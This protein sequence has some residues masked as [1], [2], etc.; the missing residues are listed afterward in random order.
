MQ[1]ADIGWNDKATAGLVPT[2]PVA[3]QHGMSPRRDLRADL[4][5]VQVHCVGIGSWQHQGSA[6]AACGADRT[7]NIRPT[8]ALIAQRTGAAAT[9]APDVGQ[10]AL[11]TDPRLIL[12][13]E[14]DGFV[15]G[16]RRDRGAD[17]VGEVFLCASCASVSACG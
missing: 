11:L 15:T 16:L 5:Q 10:A 9:F 4:A 1:Q 17:Q 2:C 14:F 13:P 8:E 7:E 6:H 12:P 3:G